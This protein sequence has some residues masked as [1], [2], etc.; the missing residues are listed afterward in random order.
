MYLCVI[1]LGQ[2]VSF[3][4]YPGPLLSRAP[5]RPQLNEWEVPR[6]ASSFVRDNGQRSMAEIGLLRE[7]RNKKEPSL[8]SQWEGRIRNS[9]QVPRFCLPSPTGEECHQPPESHTFICTI[10]C[11]SPS[12]DS[13]ISFAGLCKSRE[14]KTVPFLGVVLPAHWPIPQAVWGYLRKGRSAINQL[15]A[16]KR[17][18]SHFNTKYIAGFTKRFRNHFTAQCFCSNYPENKSGS[19][20]MFN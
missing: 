18:G 8:N 4:F 10:A 15:L 20:L 9:S 11:S 6:S 14:F 1:E 17:Q 2:C 7:V 12:T 19:V 16:G 5:H 3:S 13:V